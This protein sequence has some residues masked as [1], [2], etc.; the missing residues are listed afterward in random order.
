MTPLTLQA[1]IVKDLR[2]L[3]K[4]YAY[5]DSSGTN[6]KIEIYEQSTPVLDTEDET[7]VF[8]YVEVRLTEGSDDGESHLVEI[9]FVVGVYDNDKTAQGYKN[10]INILDKIHYRYGTNHIV[11]DGQG[12]Q[13]G[14][15]DWLMQED[16]YFPYFFGAVVTKFAIA[17]I[18]K[19]DPYA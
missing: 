9:V 15:W 17:S 5:L 4:N 11:G 10:V 12:Y 3:F 7:D 8:P 6:K 19:E 13:T 16:A 14:K 2:E 1:A 18:Q